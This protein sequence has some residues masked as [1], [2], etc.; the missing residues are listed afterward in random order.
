MLNNLAID[1]RSIRLILLKF[2]TSLKHSWCSAFYLFVSSA[3]E[4]D[5]PADIDNAC[6]GKQ[7]QTPFSLAPSTNQSGKEN[8]A[9]K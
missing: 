8:A 4:F 1:R 3:I 5:L 6:A 7:I 2:A 9:T